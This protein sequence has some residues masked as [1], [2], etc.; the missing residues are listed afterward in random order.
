VSLA[1][2]GPRG[3]PGALVAA[4]VET[5]RMDERGADEAPPE[6]CLGVAGLL[7]CVALHELLVMWMC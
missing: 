2:A 7:G 1:V 4:R 6:R 5:I 3:L